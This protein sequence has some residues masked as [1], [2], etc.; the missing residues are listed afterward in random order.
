MDFGNV[1]SRETGTSGTKLSG[2]AVVSNDD[3]I[4]LLPENELDTLNNSNAELFDSS[5]LSNID[6]PFD[7]SQIIKLLKMKYCDNLVI[8][9]I[10]INYIRYKFDLTNIILIT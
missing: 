5:G 3:L 6:N 1:I 9:Q 2:N 7:A 10:N 8:A 4:C